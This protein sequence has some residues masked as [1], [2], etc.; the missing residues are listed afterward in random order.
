MNRARV[1]YVLD[2]ILTVTFF[3]FVTDALVGHIL[4]FL[5]PWQT[6]AAITGVAGLASM[7]VRD[8]WPEF[9]PTTRTRYIEEID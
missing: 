9:R 7:V 6:T 1:L 3:L 5:P 8:L 2:C 4:T